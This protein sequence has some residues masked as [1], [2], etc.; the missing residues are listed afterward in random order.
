VEPQ[1]MQ[2]ITLGKADY[3]KHDHEQNEL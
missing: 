2:Q 3:V 1:L